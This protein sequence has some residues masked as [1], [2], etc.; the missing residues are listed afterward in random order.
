MIWM[1][2]TN[3][4]PASAGGTPGMN[5]HIICFVAFVI[6]ITMSFINCVYNRNSSNEDGLFPLEVI[7]E[8]RNADLIDS[9]VLDVGLN[10]TIF[11]LLSIKN[12]YDKINVYKSLDFAYDSIKR[13]M[14]ELKIINISNQAMMLPIREYYIP[15]VKYFEHCFEPIAVNL[16]PLQS[17]EVLV[18]NELAKIRGEKLKLVEPNDT[19]DIFEP[20]DL[21][22]IYKDRFEFCPDLDTGKYW[23]QIEFSN[24]RWKDTIPTVWTGTIYS[25]S[26][27]I[28]IIE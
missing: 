14:I 1:K 24:Y 10:D 21:L 20:I 16:G 4:Q 28:H 15:C 18:H 6:I 5:K 26:L 13:P 12:Y 3:P 7:F 17:C 19:V 25:D 27:W 9:L 8:P 22:S 2:Q 23:V 11:S